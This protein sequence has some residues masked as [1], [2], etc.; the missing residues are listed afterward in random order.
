MKH[1]LLVLVGLLIVCVLLARI[2]IKWMKD[3]PDMSNNKILEAIASRIVLDL[4]FVAI[5]VWYLVR[6]QIPED[7]D[8]LYLRTIFM[9]AIVIAFFI[10]WGILRWNFLPPK[11]SKR[12]DSNDLK[13]T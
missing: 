8:P 1:N 9:A 10:F 6:I 13:A 2:R 11:G 4:I 7:F 5:F 3:I 12:K